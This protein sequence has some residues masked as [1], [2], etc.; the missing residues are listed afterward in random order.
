MTPTST[1]IP[2]TSLFVVLGAAALYAAYQQIWMHLAFTRP[3]FW[4][5]H[6]VIAASM[7]AVVILAF[8]VS[9]AAAGVRHERWVLATFAI[10][11]GSLVLGAGFASLVGFVFQ[12]EIMFPDLGFIPQGAHALAPLSAL[13][14][15]AAAV[16]LAPAWVGHRLRRKQA[17][18]RAQPGSV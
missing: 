17:L 11:G 16:A 18:R 12:R 14:A 9:A 10:V 4:G 6:P 3:E 5:A 7:D 1:R 2:W 15:G 13:A 8:L